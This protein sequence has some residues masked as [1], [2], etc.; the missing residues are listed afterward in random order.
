MEI[1]KKYLVREVPQKLEQYPHRHLEQSYI[2]REPV[3]RL[4]CVR[5]KARGEQEETYYLT[6]KGKGLAVREEFEMPI[7]R[8][9]YVH[10]LTKIE[11]NSVVKTRYDIPLAGG[12][13]AELDVFEGHLAGLR[14]VEVEFD[15]EEAMAS[16]EPPAWFGEDVSY[17]SRYHNSVLSQ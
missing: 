2:C 14:L 16:F 6:V 7:T 1:E 11:G 3:I 10:L 12:L 5:Q 8:Q 13:T 4:R 15:S 9:A 17:D